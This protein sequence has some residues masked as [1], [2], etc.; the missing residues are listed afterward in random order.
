M[1]LEINLPCVP[2]VFS[3]THPTIHM[4]QEKGTGK[5]WGGGRRQERERLSPFSS[6]WFSLYVTIVYI[7]LS[8]CYNKISDNSD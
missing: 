4:L 7:G 6:C 1:I 8:C 2:Q 5:V 3:K